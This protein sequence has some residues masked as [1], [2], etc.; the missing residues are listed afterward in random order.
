MASTTPGS[1]W[2]SFGQFTLDL[3]TGELFGGASPT[4]LPHQ[5]FRL[6]VTLITHRGELVTRAELHR[7]LW[8][9]DT[10][11]DFEPGLNAAVRR[12]R[13]ALG[14]SAE[15]P[16]FIQ[17][18]PR[19]GY[20][21]IAPVIEGPI[22]ATAAE[23][24]TATRAAA[25]SVSDADMSAPVDWR[26]GRPQPR[27]RLRWATTAVI[28]V[29]IGVAVFVFTRSAVRSPARRELPARLTNVGTVRLASLTPDG[30]RLAY[31]RRDGARESLWLRDEGAR[32]AQLIAPVLGTFRSITFAP[33][34]FV[35]YTLLRPDATHIPLYRV[36]TKGGAP[37]LVAPVKGRVSFNRDGSRFA[38]VFTA[39]LGGQDSHVIIDDATGGTSRMVAV[40]PR[41][42]NYLNRKPAWS[43][44]GRFLASAARDAHDRMELVIIDE[45]SGTVRSRRPLS[46]AEVDDL[47]WMSD[48]TVV[49]AGR[50][51]TGM[52]R[53]LWRLSIPAMTVQPLT[54]DHA[55]YSLAGASLETGQIV[56][57]RNET[58]RAVWV[59]EVAG[60]GRPRR[61]ATDTASFEFDGLAFARDGRVVYAATRSGNVDLYAIDPQTGEHSRLTTDPA[62]DVHPAVSGDGQIAFVSERGGAPG[63]WVMARDGTRA[64]RLTMEADDWPSFSPD[65]EWVVVQRGRSDNIPATMWRV[66]VETGEAARVGPA[67]SVRPTLS[68]DGRWVAH[69]WM[70]PEQWMLAV[71]PIDSQ[72]P[73]RTLPVTGTHSGRIIRWAPDARSLAF[74]DTGAGV[75]S[76]WLQ[77]LDGGPPRP[78]TRIA[79]GS[80]ATFD[81]SPDGTTLAWIGVTDVSDVITIPLDTRHG[82]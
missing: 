9:S 7:E 77:P 39:S 22:P 56:A 33:G 50:E 36:S 68:P 60:T 32:H 47:L 30:R 23:A 54:D 66:S 58:T 79:D 72:L 18:L 20:R 75:S 42:A 67:E 69:Y 11:V 17:T 1:Q 37:A 80:V 59:G 55:S 24:S 76:V 57:V 13:D 4:L 81:W 3:Q 12:L 38:S 41:P 44:D 82:S 6:L 40:L 51:R 65:G 52:P 53:R 8:S 19:R 35:Y 71:T 29:M 34:D 62:A 25:T 74:V 64:R 49:V 43:P 14:D 48:D 15:A 70:T 5:P 28:L 26:E 73:S 16:Q 78:L 27:P 21:F 46:F 63:L 31:V 10:F 45:A 2:V 61:V